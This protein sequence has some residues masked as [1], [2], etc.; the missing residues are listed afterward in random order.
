MTSTINYKEIHEGDKIRVTETRPN[1]FQITR[2]GVAEKHLN[3]SNDGDR[4]LSSI[5][6]SSP[7]IVLVAAQLDDGVTREIELIERFVPKLPTQH[8]TIIRITE[9]RDRIR[10]ILGSRLA[11]LD[12]DDEWCA[13]EFPD[14]IGCAYIEP[15]DILAWNHVSIFDL[16]HSN[17]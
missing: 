11:I 13:F 3:V 1:G 6:D 15:K 8:G 10:T 5:D 14:D 12:T 4:W 17:N 16:P 7:L 9:Y 2:L